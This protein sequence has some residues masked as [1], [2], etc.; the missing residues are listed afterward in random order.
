MIYNICILIPI[1]ILSYF[2][3]NKYIAQKKLRTYERL[4]QNITQKTERK[5][6]YKILEK[7]EN[8][9]IKQGHPLG[10]NVISY[11]F[12][13]ILL[14]SC[15][16]F[17]SLNNYCDFNIAI[18]NAI[19]GFFAIDGFIYFNKRIRDSQVCS[20]LLNVVDCIYL[21]LSAHV[22]L[23]NVLKGIGG[24]CRNKDLKNALN[25]LSTRYELFE[26]NIEDSVSEFQQKFDIL[27]IDMFS[28]A[29]KQ[30]S[31]NNSILEILNNLS[32]ILKL[33]YLDKL[34]SDTKTKVIL[35]TL[36]VTI[37]LFNIVVLI[38][39]PIFID[40]SKNLHQIFK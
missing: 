34:N 4:S 31:S 5:Y 16:Y 23:K 8:M 22:N 38:T 35:I 37:I 26:Y 39:F 30:Q 12:F 2:I 3:A 10:L 32:N 20:D 11:F 19:F 36:G 1:T 40:V 15:L 17:I 27:E 33:R 14:F 28:N 9:L 25:T 21:Q 6:K 7:T 18:I 24:V 29:I 13:K